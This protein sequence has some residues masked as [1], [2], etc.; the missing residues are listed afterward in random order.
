MHFWV[1]LALAG[2]FVVAEILTMSLLFV[3]LAIA[4]IAGAVASAIWS[5]SIAQWISF[6]IV[7]VLTLGVLRPFARRYLSRKAAG[8]E[9]GID[10]LI[11]SPAR[12]LSEITSTSGIIRLRNETWTAHCE[13]DTIPKGTDVIVT[14]I[15]GAIAIVSNSKSFDS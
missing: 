7:A 3:S 9:T 1:W 12:T 2:G 8:G 11:L 5:N 4:A 10:A 6:A 15:D 13:S 14:R